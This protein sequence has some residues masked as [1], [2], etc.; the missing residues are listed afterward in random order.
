MTD[1]TNPKLCAVILLCVTALLCTCVLCNAV[2][3]Y[4]AIPRGSGITATGSASLDFESD[5]IVWRGRFW[6]DAGSL[7]AAYKKLHSDAELVKQYLEE[8]EIREDEMLFGSVG[9]ERKT[10]PVYDE[11]GNLTEYRETGY[12]L[13]QSFVVSS[14][15]L[16]KTAAVSRNISELIASGIELESDSPQ[17]YCTRLDEIKMELIEAASANAR[18]RIERMAGQA[19]ARKGKLAT[20]NLGVFQITA[21]HSG[22]GDYGATGTLDT[23]S[24]Y[25]TAMITV[26]LNYGVK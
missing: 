25:K 16:D 6:V 3:R 13:T 17:Y 2:I 8:E 21:L 7:D 9:I 15:E 14:E 20:A 23:S 11:F 12:H 4:K 24:R 26:K 5:L 19:G 22:T 1:K 18:E 10:T